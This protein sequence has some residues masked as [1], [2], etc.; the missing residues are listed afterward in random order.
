M[1]E[2]SHQNL[3]KI[4]KI[5]AEKLSKK[6]CIYLF[7]EIGVGKTS[8]TRKLINY[9]QKKAGAKETEVLSPTFNILHEYKVK[10]FHI[11]HYDLYRL[12]KIKEL[13]NLDII[14]N[15]SDFIKIIEWP[16]ILNIKFKDRLEVRISYCKN[17]NKRKLNFKG[18]GRWSKFEINEL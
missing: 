17:K 10:K 14:N 13:K 11:L 5:I 7:G 1:I 3:K 12:K 6:D 18:F 15:T 2:A 9:L 16:E 8:L 4:A